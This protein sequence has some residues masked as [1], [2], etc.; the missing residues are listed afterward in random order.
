MAFFAEDVHLL[1]SASSDGKVFVRRIVES[2]GEDNKMQIT[3]EVL[4]AIQLTGDWESAHPRVCW[5]SHSQDILVVGVS[6]YILT[7]DIPT[8]RLT[9]APGGFTTDEPLICS[10]DNPIPGVYCVVGHDGDVTDISTS[11]WTRFGFGKIKICFQFQL[12]HLMKDS[13]L[14]Q[15]HSF[16]LL[17]ILIIL[18]S[19]PWDL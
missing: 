3:E 4:L 13:K 8:V 9:G 12:S 15:L 1:A 16:Q 6:K 7:L 19:F 14:M 10:V 2:P 18:F 11:Q 17:T 5:H